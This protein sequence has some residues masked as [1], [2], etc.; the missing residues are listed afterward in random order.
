MARQNQNLNRQEQY[1]QYL[2][3]NRQ[4][5]N[6]QQRREENPQNV[7]FAE[8]FNAIPERQKQRKNNQK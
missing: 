5:Q 4:E 8:D 6:E 1:E 3:E 7:E 2:R